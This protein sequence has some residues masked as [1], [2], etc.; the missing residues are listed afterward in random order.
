MVFFVFFFFKSFIKIKKF[1]THI[2]HFCYSKFY[3][4]IFSDFTNKLP[5]M[6]KNLIPSIGLSHWIARKK[7]EEE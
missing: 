1:C 4:E 5:F 7:E 2:Q 3:N 6:S